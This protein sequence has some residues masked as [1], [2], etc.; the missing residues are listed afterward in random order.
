MTL[1]QE[2]GAVMMVGFTGTMTPAVLADWRLRQYGGLIVVQGNQ[3]ATNPTAIR[4]MILEIRAAAGHTLLAAAAEEGGGV[5]LLAAQV[6]CLAGPRQV[7]SQGPGAIESQMRTMSSGLRGLGFDVNLA[8]VANVADGADSA[9]DER[10]YGQNAQT[11]AQDVIAAIAGIH[12]AGMYSVAKY[13][14]ADALPFRAAI[15]AQADFVMVAS[16]P[17]SPTQALRHGLGY[18]GLVISD[19]LRAA[20]Q[21]NSPSWAAV[22]FLKDG[23][24]MVIVSHDLAVADAT[25]NA[26]H[27]AVLE[28]SYSRAQLDAS[29]RKLL[30][31]NLKFMP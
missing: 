8:P 28:G 1:G 22:Q 30:N 12:A 18:R 20:S 27:T 29:V 13:F 16:A 14:S 4:Q 10:S 6:P 5:C 15:G 25:D 11:V 2:V 19:D 9:L 7:A 17:A 21:P 31:L 24:D 23:G 26:I 3:N